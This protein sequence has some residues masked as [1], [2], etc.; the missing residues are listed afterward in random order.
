MRIELIYLVWKTSV[1]PLNY[2]YFEKDLQFNASPFTTSYPM[3]IGTKIN[4]PT[5]CSQHNPPF[6]YSTACC[7][8]K[9]ST[10]YHVNILSNN[11][12]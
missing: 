7:I 6:E 5:T 12:D 10:I 3:G 2:I 8:F 9:V 11:F 1:L 4:M